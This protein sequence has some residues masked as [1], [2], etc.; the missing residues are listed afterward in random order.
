M[1]ISERNLASYLRTARLRAQRPGPLPGSRR[2][3]AWAAA[4]RAAAFIRERCPSARI[5]AFG[6]LLYPD[7]F[8][9][10]S[11]IDLAVEGVE[12][13]EYLRVWSALDEREPAFRIDLVDVGIVS[14]GLRTHIEREGVLL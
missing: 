3:E 9:P 6:S 10:H 1:G 8:G 7:S 2:E 14:D 4:R 11:D 12:W 13:P 5:R